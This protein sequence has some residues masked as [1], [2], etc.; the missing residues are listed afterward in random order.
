MRKV[1]YPGSFDPLTLGHIN[2]I[3]RVKSQVDHLVILVSLS[4]SKNYMFSPEER[5]QLI[6]E[7]FHEDP[8][9]SV[10][11]HEGLTVNYMKL[12]DIKTIVRGVRT[13]SDFEMEHSMSYLNKQLY[14][15]IE[16]F[17]I[18]SDPI[19]TSISSRFIKEIAKNGGSL[20]KMVPKNV[21]KKLIEQFK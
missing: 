17:I 15:E 12:H 16:T 21:E 9:I 4:E 5:C 11:T 6:K 20:N 8:Q 3:E 7:Y 19:Y 14:S 2:I 18:F 10:E 13:V 1:I